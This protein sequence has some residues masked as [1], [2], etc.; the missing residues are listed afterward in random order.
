MNRINID[1]FLILFFFIYP[2]LSQLCTL[3][4]N[5]TLALL[6]GY[7]ETASFSISCCQ[8][9]AT[10]IC[11]SP[12]S[13]F[14][15]LSTQYL[16]ICMRGYSGVYCSAFIDDEICEELN[17]I[18]QNCTGLASTYINNSIGYNYLCCPDGVNCAE[19]S[20][21]C[22]SG[23]GAA[24][25][26]REGG[27]AITCSGISPSPYSYNVSR[28]MASAINPTTTTNT[29]GLEIGIPIA[30]V[31]LLSI[32]VLAILKYKKRQTHKI[33]EINFDWSR[34]EVKPDEIF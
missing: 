11:T 21:Y 24:M 3:N 6:Y 33:I 14:E 12:V 13:P 8:S 29:T 20:T 15:C 19:S 1:M 9:N 26:V 22:G 17:T 25:C 23:Q 27:G 7:V 10:D 30:G 31:V 34:A 18:P 2:V 32:I 16:S 28:C 4:V 5:S